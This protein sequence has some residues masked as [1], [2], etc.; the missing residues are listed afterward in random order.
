MLGLILATLSLFTELTLAEKVGQMLVSEFVGEEAH[1]LID[2][3]HIG[4]VIYYT[5]TNKLDSAD[6]VR[7][8]STSLQERTKIPLFTMIDHEGGRVQHL[9]N[10]F[11]DLPAPRDQAHSTPEQVCELNYRAGLELKDV[12]VNFTLAPVVDIATSPRSYG[13]DPETVTKFARAAIEGFQKAGLLT[14][15]KHFPGHGRSNTDSHYSLP[16]LDELDDSDLSPFEELKDQTDA[17]MTGHLLVPT[18][19]PKFCATLSPRILGLI[20]NEFDKLIITDS[21]A[22]RGLLDNMAKPVDA[23]IQAIRAGADILLYGGQELLVA[24]G[25]RSGKISVKDIHASIVAAVR[26]GTLSEERIDQSVRRILRV[27]QAPIKN[28]SLYV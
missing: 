26:K 1:E 9:R 8:L 17:I 16:V 18:L 12:G 15:I 14:C 10:G 19:D 21:M 22:M 28:I 7:D 23:A 13:T 2:D 5:H 24:N 11:T 3:V 4:G 27:K 25:E 20:R 6:Q